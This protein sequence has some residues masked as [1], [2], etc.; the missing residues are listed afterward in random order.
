VISFV[1]FPFF[2]FGLKIRNKSIERIVYTAPTYIAKIIL[3]LWGVRLKVYHTDVFDPSAQYVFIGNHLSYADAAISAAAIPNIKKYI[4]KAELLKLPVIGYILENMYIPV[5]RDDASSRKWSMEQLFEKTRDGSSMVIYPESTCNPGPDILLPFKDG[6]FRL[7]AGINAGI[8]CFT[9]IGADKIWNRN[10]LH[11][12][13]P[14]VVSV[15]F[16]PPFYPKD[17]TEDEVE[18][19][20]SL[21][22]ASFKEM[23]L[24]KSS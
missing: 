6:A 21:A 23:I 18:R 13:K 16:S 15:Y 24:S 9:A 4:G 14:G 8:V 20:K 12:I 2:Y 7:A 1:C 19:L 5:Q 3:F 10:S 11:I 22:M 17:N